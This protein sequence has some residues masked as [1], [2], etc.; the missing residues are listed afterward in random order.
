MGK[1]KIG[2]SS[3]HALIISQKY[4][5]DLEQIVDYIEFVK[6]QPLNAIKVGNGIQK[7]MNKIILNPTIYAECENIPTKSKI[8]REAGYKSWLIVFKLK[9][10]VI[11]ILGVLSGKRKP[12]WFRE[13]K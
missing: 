1:E 10:N 9:G 6:L 8:Y 12:S 7:T 13:I 5:E 3:S 11:T 4:Y 2:D